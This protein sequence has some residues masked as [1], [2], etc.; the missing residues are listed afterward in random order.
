V[1]VVTCDN[2]FTLYLNGKEIASGKEW[3]K[4][5]LVDLKSHLV[6]GENVIAVA[7]V[8]EAAF[9]DKK[10][11]DKSELQNNPAGFLFYARVRHQRTEAQVLIER[12]WD[13]V[14]DSSWLCTGAKFADWE[15]PDF[16]PDDWMPVAEL[17]NISVQPWQLE[18]RFMAALSGAAQ[19][20]RT[21]A[22]LVASVAAS[23]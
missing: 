15:K 11:S 19:H 5:K 3:K 7:A 13:V 23:A 9:P 16:N 20:N 21:R 17:G 2:S 22:S 10:T 6:K 8:N 12:V 1:A 18:K 14:S 4:P